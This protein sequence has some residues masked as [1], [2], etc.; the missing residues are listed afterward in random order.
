VCRVKKSLI[1]LV[2][3]L[4]LGTPAAAQRIGFYPLETS[5][6]N[7]SIA[8]PTAVARV[9]EAIDGAILVAPS[10]LFA[11]QKRRPSFEDKLD[12]IFSLA[13]FITGK[14]EGSAGNY[15]VT[16]TIKSGSSAAKTVTAKG[17]DF[18]KLVAASDD[19]I[20]AALGLKPSSTDTAEVEAIEKSVPTGEVV[21]AS[22]AVLEEGSAAILE[23]AGQQPWALYTRAL[24]LMQQGKDAEALPL[25]VSAAKLA[26]LDP[27]AT[28]TLALAQLSNRNNAE[29]KTAIDAGLKLNP[30]KPEL[31]YLQGRYILR[32]TT[33][34]TATVLRNALA[35]LQR[36]MQYNPR[37]LEASVISADLYERLGDVGNAYNALVNLVPR[38]PDEPAL[39]NRILDLLLNADRDQA[40]TYLQQ[41]IASFPDVPDTVYSLASRLFDTD[42][43]VR[44]VADGEKRYDKSAVLANARG[45]LLE[46][47]TKYTD[48]VAAYKQA[49][50]RDAKLQRAGLSLAGALSKLGRFDEAEGAIQAAFGRVDQKL[51]A[52]MYLQTG[53][54]DR[55]DAVLDKLATTAPTD[56][57]VPYYQGVLLLR[58]YQTDAARKQLEAAIK[59]KPDDARVKE[60]LPELPDAQ[61]LGAPKLT[62]EALYQLQL[63]QSLLDARN[64][65]EAAVVLQAALKANP[66]DLHLNFYYGYALYQVADPDDAVDQFSDTLKLAPD[67]VVVMSWLALTY[68][69]NGRMDLAVTTANQSITKDAK[70]ARAYLVLG[71]ANFALGNVAQAREAFLKTVGVNADFKVLVDP[72]LNALPK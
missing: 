27:G 50:E 8:V 7:L 58:Q 49:L 3:L 18:Q 20:I 12:G 63:A 64:P 23:R 6:T 1:F 17:A 16:Y 11:A 43:A 9:L 68:I 44:L 57:D 13:H 4:A 46:R 15:T 56:V 72:Y 60:T 38:M 29:A 53:R 30:A 41:V 2:G 71:L 28:A 25:A 40:T 37:F 33:P 45:N 19:A 36:A 10:D 61:K 59:L 65:L 51:L 5:D 42:V 66:R 21:A 24:V 67:N 22:V 14:L 70:Y 32:A 35:S 34:A 54:F 47:Q 31:H 39:H 26:P 55:A 69:S 62:G 48:A 52:R